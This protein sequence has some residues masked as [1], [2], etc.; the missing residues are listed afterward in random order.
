VTDDATAG[1]PVAAGPAVVEGPY[2]EE[3]EVGQAFPS[4]PS[5]TLTDGLAAVHQAILGDRLRLSLD[6]HLSRRVTGSGVLA[7]PGLVWDLAIGHST[8]VTEHVVANLFYRGLSFRRLPLIGDS[9]RTRTE[10]VGLRQHTTR[11]GR[12]RTGAAVLR[13]TTV[14]HDDRLVLDF[15]RCAMLP[16]RDQT[17]ETGR[18][19]DVEAV[20]A[21]FAAEPM[22][23]PALVEGWDFDAYRAAPGVGRSRLAAGAV[24][25]VIGAQVV[26]G[27]P[28]LVRSTLNLARVHQDAALGGGSRLVYGG[29]TIGIAFAHL[30]RALPEVVAVVGWRGCDHLAPVHEGDMLTSTV[31]VEHVQPWAH[32]LCLA[33]LHVIVHS[34]ATD[35]LDWRLTV[36]L[37]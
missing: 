37:P 29:H 31:S 21:A 19:D 30:L 27:A 4:V 12:R 36:I 5:A 34:G 14:D 32:D 7:H 18:H 23:D 22:I 1:D 33:Q 6:H 35:V 25:D 28:E 15:L 3:L 26:S 2:F 11:P 16:L 9:I 24:Y 13:I 17:L 10:V 8:V 20:A